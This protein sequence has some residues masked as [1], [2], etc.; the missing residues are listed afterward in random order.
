MKLHTTVLRKDSDCLFQTA[1]ISALRFVDDVA[2]EA[3]KRR[4]DVG[5]GPYKREADRRV[6]RP[7]R[8]SDISRRGSFGC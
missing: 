7:Q 8:T 6:R 3:N 4:V 2:H 1:H 5:D